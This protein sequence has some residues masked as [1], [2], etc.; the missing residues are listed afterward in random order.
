MIGEYRNGGDVKGK[1]VAEFEALSRQSGYPVFGPKFESKG[2]SNT[3]QATFG[4]SVL[5]SAWSFVVHRCMH[6]FIYYVCI[7]IFHFFIGIFP[8]QSV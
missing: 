5:S 2:L 6:I 1:V 4:V 8:R 3:T 7:H